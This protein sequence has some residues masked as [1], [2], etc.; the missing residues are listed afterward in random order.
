VHRGLLVFYPQVVA[1]LAAA[2]ERDGRAGPADL[3]P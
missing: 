1:A 3:T 2:A